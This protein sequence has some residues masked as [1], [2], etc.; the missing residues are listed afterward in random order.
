M[1][2]WIRLVLSLACGLLLAF[3]LCAAQTKSEF[4][5]V[6]VSIDEVREHLIGDPPIVRVS[7]PEREAAILG[8]EG[9]AGCRQEGV[10]RHKIAGRIGCQNGAISAF[11]TRW[12]T[13]QRQL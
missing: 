11:R 8:M 2:Y 4:H 7:L 5:P 13:C 10:S 3:L 6:P 12:A 9:V 1:R